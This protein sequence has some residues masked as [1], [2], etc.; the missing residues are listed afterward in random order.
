MEELPRWGPPLGR[1]LHALSLPASCPPPNEKYFNM[2]AA[3]V[4][5]GLHEVKPKSR[6]L[7]KISAIFAPPLPPPPSGSRSRSEREPPLGPRRLDA[8]AGGA[9]GGSSV[10]WM[11]LFNHR[12]IS[13]N[14]RW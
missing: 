8:R 9:K 2:N 11:S 12:L 4:L 6:L 1:S 3:E 13:S 14:S 10:V 7:A 5:S